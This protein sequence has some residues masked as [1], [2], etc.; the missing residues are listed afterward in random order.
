MLARFFKGDSF[1]LADLQFALAIVL[2]LNGEKEVATPVLQMFA[3]KPDDRKALEVYLRKNNKYG[4]IYDY[5]NYVYNNP[6]IE[7]NV[8][9]MHNGLQKQ[10]LGVLVNKMSVKKIYD[11]L[12]QLLLCTDVNKL[13]YVYMSTSMWQ[14]YLRNTARR[15]SSNITP[16]QIEALGNGFRSYVR[17]FST[18]GSYD[19]SSCTPHAFLIFAFQSFYVHTEAYRD[20]ISNKSMMRSI[21][22]DDKRSRAEMSIDDIDI[23]QPEEGIDFMSLA[24]KIYRSSYSLFNHVGDGGIA[25]YDIFSWYRKSIADKLWTRYKQ[26]L[27]SKFASIE[28]SRE[29]MDYDGSKSTKLSKRMKLCEMYASRLMT[30]GIEISNIYDFYL[31]AVKTADEL[32]VHMNA[33][34]GANDGIPY[35]ASN[36]IHPKKGCNQD[37]FKADFEGFIALRELVAFLNSS[38]N[39]TGYTIFDFPV[40]IFRDRNLLKRF[41][42]LKEYLYMH[43]DVNKLVNEVYQSPGRSE[44]RNEKNLVS[45]DCIFDQLLSYKLN[46][47]PT[48]IKKAYSLSLAKGREAVNTIGKTSKVL[49]SNSYNE[50]NSQI[51]NSWMNRMNDFDYLDKRKNSV[52]E[53]IG[54]LIGWYKQLYGMMKATADKSHS[55]MIAATIVNVTATLLYE[56]GNP[57]EQKGLYMLKENDINTEIVNAIAK[58]KEAFPYD[59]RLVVAFTQMFETSARI[60]NGLSNADSIDKLHMFTAFSYAKTI[61]KANSTLFEFCNFIVSELNSTQLLKNENN[62][63]LL[64]AKAIATYRWLD[65]KFPLQKREEI[66]LLC[67]NTCRLYMDPRNMSDV[68]KNFR[69]IY[70]REVDALNEMLDAFKPLLD[71]I[72]MFSNSL[73]VELQETESAS[74]LTAKELKILQEINQNILITKRATKWKFYLDSYRFD[75]NNYLIGRAGIGML[76]QDDNRKTFVHKYG[77]KV[78]LARVNNSQTY[79]TEILELT[80]YE[81]ERIKWW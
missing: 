12:M 49:L 3:T 77:Y 66:T 4:I 35:Y 40:E 72:E 16:D 36:T 18:N 68:S 28:F 45:N 74:T 27:R 59:M 26:T 23:E 8:S 64:Y 78:V 25:Y 46:N 11:C 1:N 60:L 9:S 33:N 55:I 19:T 63:Y 81:V 15:I 29:T 20:I 41:S 57:V 7:R 75:A 69:K 30:T 31:D 34:G 80:Q 32:C 65:I 38:A 54:V 48:L 47:S 50:M 24:G 44:D 2:D 52:V 5:V 22:K 61:Y 70:L 39:D 14:R 56:L 43:D 13:I 62:L 67:G 53:K 21:S 17:S 71:F 42:S 37:K 76:S 79:H 51:S 73:H 58:N 10:S 6:V